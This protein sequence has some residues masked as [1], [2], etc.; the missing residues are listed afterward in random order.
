M[1]NYYFIRYMKNASIIILLC[2]LIA[3]C[4][5]WLERD[6][7]TIVSE[8]QV[9]NDSKQI[10]A[11]LANYYDRLPSLSGFSGDMNLGSYFDDASWSGTGNAN[12]QLISYPYS[13][14]QYWDY[15]FIRDINLAIENLN[16]YSVLPENE[17]KQ[18]DAEFRFIRSFVYFELVKR[19]GGVPLITEQLIYDYSGDAS[20][21]QFPRAKES[22]IYDF[23]G[24]EIDAIEN[25][26]G[27]EGSVT[28][29]NKYTALALKS[30]AMLYAA[31]LAK[32]N[33]LMPEPIKT[34]NGEV[35]IEA[36]KANGYYQKSLEA[37]KKIITSGA[38]SLY[39]KNADLGEN[40][41]EMLI[42]KTGNAE[43]IFAKD[44]SATLGKR[45]YFTYNNIAR[46]AREESMG[47]SFITPVLNL[48]ESYEYLDGSPGTLK[49][50]TSDGSDYIY[51]NNLSDIF[52]NKD[53]RLYGTVVYPGTKFRGIDIDLQ[54]GVKV[55]NGTGYETVEG[56][57]I[58]INY[59]DGGLLV[60]TSGPH[61]SIEMVSNTGFNLRKMVSTAPMASG[62]VV[63]ADNWWPWFRLG[64]IY[65]NAAEAAFELNLPEA[66]NYINTLRER[67]GFPANSIT[68]LTIDIIRNER[69]VELAF[70]DHRYFDLKRWRIAHELW[71]GNTSNPNA[72]LYALYAYRIVHPGSPNNGKYVFEK[73]VAPRFVNP[74]YF[75]MGNYYS[76]IATSVMTNNPKIIPNPFH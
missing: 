7:K 72:M 51:Y 52:K 66:T 67:A 8:E 15:T 2:L 28:R 49:N 23:I 24:N 4:D 29:A 30:R 62:Q 9:W 35:G 22:E 11:L 59:T 16:K 36:S 60:G 38:Y 42:T 21:L 44:Y 48:V 43:I 53:A 57:S 18:F 54:A 26:I 50:K 27:N 76:S 3:S 6:S 45:H 31:S 17:K 58:G 39:N 19:M 47:S 5:D 14:A 34:A 55:W 70:E 69:R 71:D 32:Y 61:R 25:V 64:E 68:N 65:L 33:N 75:Q 13:F 12:N 74:R 40:F 10:L 73:L 41:Y 63:L 46:G 20:N 37:S 1:N 56:S